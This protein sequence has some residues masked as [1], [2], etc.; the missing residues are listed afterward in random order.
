MDT[1]L[2]SRLQ[3]AYTI[4]FHYIFPQ[5]TIGLGLLLVF[6]EGMYLRTKNPAYEVMTRF[7]VK[8][9][10]LCFVV[11][12]ASGVVM[13]F[14]FGTNWATYSRFDGE[15][16]GS[17]LAAEGIFAF[18]LES[19]FLGL[20]IFGWDKVSPR[21]HF[22][23]TIMV[24][25][26]AHMSAVWILVANSWQQTPAGHRIVERGG[27]FRAEIVD[28][29]AMVFNPSTFD[30]VTHTV[31][32]TWQAG[33]FLVLSVGAF[34][35]LKKRHIEFAKSSIKIAL[36]VAAFSSIMQ[37]VTG[38]QSAQVVGEYQPAKLAAFEGHYSDALEPAP[39]YIVGWV[40]EKDHK[41]YGI[42]VP[43]LLSFLVHG[44]FHEPVKG[45]LSFPSDERPPVGL[46][47][48]S[49][50][51]M[52]MIGMSLI[53]LSMLGVV[54]WWTGTLFQK[55]WMLVLFVFSVLCPQIAN[56]AGWISTEVGRQP[57]VVYGILKTA[58]AVSKTLSFQEVLVSFIMF[59]IV[60]LLLFFV[61][62]YLLTEMVLKGPG[63]SG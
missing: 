47:F 25:L 51:L 3:F 36:V 13:E 4:A 32:G 21:W 35:L 33:A 42:K 20:L 17:P 15:V 39:S 10:G 59:G 16:F 11:G 7:W 37:L 8:V 1:V 60:Y 61:F 24:A 54:F 49:F 28:F 48:Q 14:Q 41:V 19:T 58:D 50:H 31:L 30:R 63:T 9:F 22:F 38:H 57:W 44:N 27:Q 18:F 26:G 29:W 53:L 12:V 23:S 43:G 6:M 2:L 55:K 62:L 34:Y 52:V 40:N 46:V 56:Q 45:L 5:L